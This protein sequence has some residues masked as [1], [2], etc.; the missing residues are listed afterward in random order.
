M[1]KLLL[2]LFAF[3]AMVS[4]A[5][6]DSSATTATKP[7]KAT[8]EP[9]KLSAQQLDKVNAGHEVHKNI[10]NNVRLSLM[11]VG[12]SP[13]SSSRLFVGGLSF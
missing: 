5:M 2:S 4:V 1:K 10:I 8:N 13:I 3:G 7:T 6:A 11:G 9:M 12:T